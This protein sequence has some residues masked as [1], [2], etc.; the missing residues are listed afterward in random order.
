MDD[1]QQN[2]LV[3]ARKYRPKKFSE[4]IGQ[5]VLVRTLSNS[6]KTGRL[7]HAFIL[8]G[9]RGVGKTTTARLMARALNCVG[10]DGKS[11]PTTE[12]CGKCE[13]C[14]AISQEK[15][16]DV[17][18]VDAA[19]RTGVDDVRD[20]IDGVHYKPSFGRYKVYIIDEVHML[21]KSA[22]NALLKT[23]EEPPAHVK[24]VFATTEI[25][26]VPVTVLSRCQRFDLRRVE[27]SVMQDYFASLLKKEVVDFQETALTLL[28]K[29]ADGSVRDGLS[30]LDQAING[31]EGE[32]TEESVKDMLGLNDKSE[33][34]DL[35]EAVFKG[36]VE[37]AL[38]G[39]QG[40]LSKGA[41]PLKIVQDL[42]EMVHA[43]TALKVNPKSAEVL[44][45]PNA[46]M[47]RCKEIS[48]NLS[49]PD[50]SMVWQVLIKGQQELRQTILASQT[51]E[52]I[53]IRAMHVKAILSA[54]S[55][56]GGGGQS[57]SE[58]QKGATTDVPPIIQ[59]AAPRPQVAPPDNFADM[60]KLFS[61]KREPI[62]ASHL[63]Y[64]VRVT[65]FS[66]GEIHLF[67]SKTVPT[68]FCR[69][70]LEKLLEW[71][72]QSWEIIQESDDSA[73]TLAEQRQ[74]EH[75]ELMHKLRQNP[76]IQKIMEAYPDAKINTI[77]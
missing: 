76:E 71:T 4:V 14:T 51:L 16:V 65:K 62:L 34:I 52:M 27:V 49:V 3:L 75:Q 11:G 42:M 44:A 26:K 22:F 31:A 74:S 60:V 45:I 68:T 69:S 29:A 47:Q 37:K 17:I 73:P 23:L 1:V 20:L 32:I 56:A 67:I 61:D 19:S 48:T 54:A 63:E 24:F 46:E 12:P 15:H 39:V 7:A 18:E 55:G 38:A 59:T 9:V 10:V 58:P 25:R 77:Q 40:L 21:S 36:T 8:T 13:Q 35:T 53:I 5:D 70:V 50:I 30:L 6:I 72:G 2:Y 57:K 33:M 41:E 28:C 64:D 43:L 66:I